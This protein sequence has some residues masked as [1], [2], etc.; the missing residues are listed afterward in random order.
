MKAASDL[1]ISV[2][3]LRYDSLPKQILDGT[4]DTW[5]KALTIFSDLLIYAPSPLLAVID[6]IERFERLK[7]HKAYID[8]LVELPQNPTARQD[9]CGVLRRNLK[10]LFTTVT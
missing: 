7:S 5:D 6:G 9:D 2:M 8:S 4:I 1:N 3:Y 10:V